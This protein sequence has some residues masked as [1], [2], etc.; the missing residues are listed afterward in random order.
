MINGNFA[1]AQSGGPTAAINASLCGVIKAA[2]ADNKKIYGMVNG[3]KGAID[4]NFVDL[5]E[6]FKDEHNL[7]LLKTTPA[8]YLGS[9]RYRLPD[10]DGKCDV[11]EKIFAGFAEKNITMVIYIGGN[12]SMDTVMRL[13]QYAEKNEKNVLFAGVPKTI[14]NDLMGTD[15]T[16]GFGSA[17]KFVATTVLEIARDCAVYKDRSATVVEI[18]GRNAGW[19]TAASALARNSTSSAPHLIYLPEVPLSKEKL[20]SDIKNCKER[21]IVIAV[22]EGI[23]NENGEYYSNLDCNSG[24]DKFGHAQLCGSAKVIE[25]IIKENFGIKTRSV[26]LNVLQRCSSHFASL[27][28][29]NEAEMIGAFGAKSLLSGKTGITVGFERIKDYEIKPVINDVIK[30]AN[31]EKTVPDSF[32]AKSGNDITEKALN[33]LRPL[34]LGEPEIEI[35]NGIPKHIAL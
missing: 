30:V 15:H 26:E 8:A 27:T 25:N 6:I 10:F 35:E 17:A 33:Y 20:I 29:L 4:N 28:D 34:I 16:P 31:L 21:N 18:M 2:T 11:Y 1:V 23:K 12:D 3:I 13:S 22:S 9:C 7:K 24:H 14:D 32:I 19:L 5:G